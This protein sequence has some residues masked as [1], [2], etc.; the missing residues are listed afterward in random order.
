[1]RTKG[2]KPTVRTGKPQ[3]GETE[4]QF[5]FRLLRW[6]MGSRRAATIF[7]HQRIQD[8]PDFPV[9]SIPVKRQ[10]NYLLAQFE[11]ECLKVMKMGND[12]LRAHVEANKKD[13]AFHEAFEKSLPP[14]EV[15]F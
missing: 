11:A 5:R 2:S 8:A 9:I 10:L 7:A 12:E 1:M 6:E 14:G 15:P 4:E 3:K 13:E